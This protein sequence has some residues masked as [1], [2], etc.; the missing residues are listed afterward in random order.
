M[1]ETTNTHI[2]DIAFTSAVKAVQARKGS[3]R[4]YE[5]MEQAGSW[6]TRITPHLKDF[7]Q[8]QTSVFLATANAQGQ[9]YIQH[10]GGQAGFLKVIDDQTIGFVDFSGNRQFITVGNLAENPKAHLF[11]M[12]YIQRRRVKIWG[13][14]SVI[15]ASEA[16]VAQLMPQG[17][18]ARAEHIVIFKVI[19]W[20]ENCPKHIPQRF[21]A[22]QVASALA[23]RRRRIE[24]LEAEIERLRSLIG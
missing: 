6:E 22:A 18:E 7:I 19:A 20:D 5:R 4:A 8:A 2:S 12:D 14:G 3:R 11:L 15:E 17:C 23:E 21:E 13:E 24:A 16:L 1:M 10:R 9:P